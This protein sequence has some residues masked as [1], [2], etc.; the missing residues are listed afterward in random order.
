[1]SFRG[2]VGN[3]SLS[4]GEC[5]CWKVKIWQHDA[6]QSTTEGAGYP[7]QLKPPLPA[8]VLFGSGSALLPFT[9]IQ[10]AFFLHPWGLS[11]HGPW[12]ANCTSQLNSS[13]VSMAVPS[14]CFQWAPT[15][16]NCPRLSHPPERDLSCP[17]LPCWGCITGVGRVVAKVYTSSKEKTISI[18]KPLVKW[19]HSYF[20]SWE[21]PVNEIADV[22]L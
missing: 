14:S 3:F 13:H 11:D 17:A 16:S 10:R 5:A 1:M 4:P 18:K 12:L 2:Q 8:A 20:C 6:L 22:F 9:L 15:S 21:I 7:Q 19:N